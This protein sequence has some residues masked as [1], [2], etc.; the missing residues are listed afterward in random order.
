MD[1]SQNGLWTM[2]KGEFEESV[3]KLEAAVAKRGGNPRQLFDRIRTEEVFTDRVAEFI[4]RGGLEG[5]VHQKLARAILGKN[6][7]GVEEWSA[8]YGV[9]F[10]KKQL[11]EVADFPW[12]EDVLNAPCP[13]VKGKSVKETHFAFL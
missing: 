10:T 12:N 11:R 9:N 6:F 1:T 13:F 2:T 4:L 3:R 8:L 7:F 5:S